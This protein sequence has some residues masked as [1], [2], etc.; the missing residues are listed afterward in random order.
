MATSSRWPMTTSDRN[1]RPFPFLAAPGGTLLALAL[2]LPVP[3]QQRPTFADVV[4]KASTMAAG[5]E[6]PDSGDAI[7]QEWGWQPASALRAAPDDRQPA[8]DSVLRAQVLLDRGHFAPGAIAGVN[9]TNT[10]RAIA[11]FQRARTRGQWRTRPGD[12]VRTGTGRRAR[13]RRIPGH[14]RR[15]RRPV[16]RHPLRHDR[17][18]RARCA[19][20]RLA[21][22]N[23]RPALPPQ[24][25]AAGFAQ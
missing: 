22:A 25:R 9:G 10:R 8:D 21:G 13:P 23:A 2:A 24:S 1:P 16:R 4:G 17:Q 19:G 6:A 7:E 18:G 3:A 15:R 20:L 14:R 11:A 5:A 12:L